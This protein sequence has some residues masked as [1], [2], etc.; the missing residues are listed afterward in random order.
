MQSIS[1]FKTFFK[2]F[3]SFNKDKNYLDI[4]EFMIYFFA[5]VYKDGK[6]GKSKN[7]LQRND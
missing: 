5:L 6:Y 7:Q 2:F 4:D 3:S 1:P